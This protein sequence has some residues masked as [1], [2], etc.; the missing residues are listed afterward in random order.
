MRIFRGVIIFLIGIMLAFIILS[1]FTG[2][3]YAISEEEVC[4]AFPD[5]ACAVQD[6][7][8]GTQLLLIDCEIT[9]QQRA[10]NLVNYLTRIENKMDL[11]NEKLDR[12][13]ELELEVEKYKNALMIERAS[14]DIKYTSTT[15]NSNTGTGGTNLIGNVEFE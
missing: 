7:N 13:H 9:E 8:T 3:A 2:A 5:C 4:V 1:T 14:T 11:I 6:S 10:E 15:T 12:K